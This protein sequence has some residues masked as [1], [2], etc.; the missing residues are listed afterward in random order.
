MV[1]HTAI[2]AI[3]EENEGVIKNLRP[4]QAKQDPKALSLISD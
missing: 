1:V 4:A 3:Q 2:P